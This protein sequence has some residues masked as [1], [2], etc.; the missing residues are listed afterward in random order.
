MSGPSDGNSFACCRR[1]L[2]ETARA[3][4]G[5]LDLVFVS[6]WFSSDPVDTRRPMMAAAICLVRPKFIRAQGFSGALAVLTP[7]CSP[8]MSKILVHG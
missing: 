4:Y 3:Q 7:A 5:R 6:F 2:V 8:L 1:G